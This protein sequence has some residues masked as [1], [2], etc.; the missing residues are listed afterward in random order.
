MRQY[1]FSHRFLEYQAQK[2]IEQTQRANLRIVDPSGKLRNDSN[3][4]RLLGLRPENA[5]IPRHDRKNV[6]RESDGRRLGVDPSASTL[7]GRF[8]NVRGRHTPVVG[9]MSGERA[10]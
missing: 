2:F 5:N 3:T 7:I 6:R 10:H 1:S 8:V 4:N 9:R